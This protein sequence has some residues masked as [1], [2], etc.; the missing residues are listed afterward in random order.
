MC[1]DYVVN[2]VIY[3]LVLTYFFHE[4]SSGRGKFEIR[5][6]AVKSP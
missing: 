2:K 5:A 4:T 1:H 3:D 6:A